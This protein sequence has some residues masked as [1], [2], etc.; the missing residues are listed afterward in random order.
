MSKNLDKIVIDAQV[1]QSSSWH[2][3]MGKY[4][5]SLLEA[6]SKN[7]LTSKRSFYF[8]FNS[9]LKIPT[10]VSERINQNF[11]NSE[12]LILDLELPREPRTDFSVATSNSKNKKI[13]TDELSKK[14]NKEKIHFLILALYLDEVCS[15]FPDSPVD[16]KKI[17]IYYDS[18]PLLFHKRYGAFKGFFEN[19]YLPH[20]GTVYEADKVLSISETVANDLH[21]NLGIKKDHIFSID[22]GSIPLDTSKPTKTSIKGDFILMPSGQEIR[23]NNKRAVEGFEAF[24][25]IGNKNIKLVITSTFTEEAQKE[26]KSISKDVI[27]TG[28]VNESELAYLYDNSSFVFFASE[29][30]GLG[31][32]V[33]EATSRKKVIACSNI[34][35]FKEIS[36]EGFCYFDPSSIS[37]ITSALEV[38]Y[39]NASSKLL[40]N[41]KYELINKKY[42][43]A[44]T[45]EKFVEALH[46]REKDN[47]KPIEKKNIAIFCPDPTGFSAIGKVVAESHSEYSRFFNVEYYFD[48][49]PNHKDIRP[50]VLPHIARC[51]EAS[52]FNEEDYKKYDA[53]I[54]H[55]GNSEYHLNTIRTALAFPGYAIFHDTNLGGAYDSLLQEHYISAERYKIEEKLDE[56]SIDCP[57]KNNSSFLVSL[58]SGQ[59]GIVAHSEYAVNAISKKLINE[60]PVKKINLPTFTNVYPEKIRLSTP[61]TVSFAG[62]IAKIKGIDFIENIATSKEFSTLDINIFGYSSVEPEQME[63]LKKLSHVNLVTN[64]TDF[65]F[66]NLIKKTDILMNVRLDYRGETSL[67]TL[68]Q[69]RHGGVVFVRNFGWYSELPDEA[70]VKIDNP[71]D[72][73]M[74]LKKMMNQKEELLKIKTKAFDY[75]KINHT[76]KDYAKE[77]YDLINA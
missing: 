7:K 1:F 62:I 16:C 20:T 26:L 40:D 43:W 72:I 70:V 61:I 57:E 71:D 59:K 65:E 49:G 3:G 58:S 15:V 48:R 76:H 47:Q 30:E 6:L 69:M 29:Y 74:T 54:Y 18:I 37:S 64:P 33:L 14:F 67:T 55:I 52:D 41:E 50:S 13:L 44:N 25:K 8:I 21:M 9:R 10:E 22:G 53:V 56:L 17:L 42:T 73:S 34:P 60:V 35:V 31:L 12:I 77:M 24:K 32:P 4:S 23:K 38:A 2:R 68:E 75:I 5:M 46:L 45:A 39:K 19:F 27:F 63:K 51:Y 11:P 66:H 36:Q 28:N